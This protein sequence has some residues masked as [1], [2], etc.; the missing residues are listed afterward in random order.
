MGM[1]KVRGKTALVALAVLL[2]P[3]AMAAE[4]VV[5]LEEFMANW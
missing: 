3:V 5:L 1:L 4:R 2:V